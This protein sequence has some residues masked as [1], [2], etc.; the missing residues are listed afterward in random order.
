VSELAR[1]NEVATPLAERARAGDTAAFEGLVRRCHRQ[2]HRWALVQTGDPDDA[3]DVTQEVLIRLQ[4]GIRRFRAQARFTTWLYQVT[5]NT[6]TELHRR[7]QTRERLVARIRTTHHPVSEPAAP[8]DQVVGEYGIT[9]MVREFLTELPERQREV[10]DLVDL[11]DV[12]PSEVSA[13]LDMKP[14]TVRA[15]LFRARRALRARILE[16]HPDFVEEHR[17]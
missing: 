2:I 4:R 16:R 10:F 8:P 15:N 7:R 3:D 17:S 13:M 5:R 14:V 9:D 1:L 11:Q 12:T 6:A